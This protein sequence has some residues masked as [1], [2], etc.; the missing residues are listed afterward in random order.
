MIPLL[1]FK[2][3]STMDLSV[4]VFQVHF[5]MKLTYQ[6][7]ATDEEEDDMQGANS[8]FS[9]SGESARD[10]HTKSMWDDDCPWSEWYSA[11][12][13]VKGSSYF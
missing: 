12:N 13:P 6:T 7:L 10:N 8:E 9:E 11:E 2:A 5:T 3:Y 4:H 1:I